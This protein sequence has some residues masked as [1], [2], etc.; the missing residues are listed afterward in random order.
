MIRKICCIFIINFAL[1]VESYSNEI[2]ITADNLEVNRDRKISIF[3]GNVYVL[4][5]DLEIW[6]DKLV[7]VFDIN[8]NDNEIKELNAENNVKIVKQNITAT[9][10]SGVYYPK[11][12]ILNMF[13][14]VEV[15][16]NNNLV[17][18]D[19]LLLDIENSTSIMKSG[20]SK[21]VEAYLISN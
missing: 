15:F 1:V 6:S 8:K 9:G 3:T 18:C 5:Q 17:K 12:D 20:A 4:N 21:R 19:E 7:V 2:R 11:S 16:E 14:N 10:K 13:G